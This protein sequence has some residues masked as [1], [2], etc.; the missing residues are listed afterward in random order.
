MLFSSA[1]TRSFPRSAMF[2]RG[3]GSAR[4]YRPSVLSWR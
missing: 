2:R 4:T 1:F 3:T